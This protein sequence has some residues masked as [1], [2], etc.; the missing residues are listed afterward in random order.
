[1][2][3]RIIF[4]IAAYQKN[5]SSFLSTVPRDYTYQMLVTGRLKETINAKLF[6]YCKD[7]YNLFRSDKIYNKKHILNKFI[8]PYIYVIF[9]NQP[10]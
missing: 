3:I 7:T 8:F 9:K 4:K 2:V 5:S 1:M 10:Q 6:A